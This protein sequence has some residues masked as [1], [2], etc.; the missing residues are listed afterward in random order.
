MNFKIT[1]FMY[2]NFPSGKLDTFPPSYITLR[3]LVLPDYKISAFVRRQSLKAVRCYIS[4]SRLFILADQKLTWA[5]QEYRIKEFFFFLP[6]CHWSICQDSPLLCSFTQDCWYIFIYKTYFQ[7]S[8]K[9][10]TWLLSVC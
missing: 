10:N 1:R 4:L 8:I 2:T 9:L 3:S 7:Q 5:T 6:H